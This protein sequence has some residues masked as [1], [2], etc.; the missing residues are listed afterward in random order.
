MLVN[1]SIFVHMRSCKHICVYLY[2]CI[3]M[4]A[5]VCSYIYALN[6]YMILCSAVRAPLCQIMLY[7]FDLSLL[8]AECKQFDVYWRSNT[9]TTDL[10]FFLSALCMGGQA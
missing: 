6:V 3:S 10:D 9:R 8:H 4:N 5:H 1:M 7:K 2:I